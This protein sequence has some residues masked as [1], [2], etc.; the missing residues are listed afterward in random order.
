MLFRARATLS[1][2]ELSLTGWHFGG[3]YNRVI[4]TDKI[5]HVDAKGSQGLVLWLVDGEVI[6]L[7]IGNVEAWRQALTRKR[8]L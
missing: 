6:R 7:R 5:V 1:G 2:N 8:D 4:P 3:R